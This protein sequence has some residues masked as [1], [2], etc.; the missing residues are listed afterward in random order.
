MQVGACYP[1][2]LDS[3]NHSWLEPRD[4]S[5]VLYK[6]LVLLHSVGAEKIWEDWSL[7]HHNNLLYLM[8]FINTLLSF[9]FT[10]IVRL[11]YTCWYTVLIL[12]SIILMVKSYDDYISN[13]SLMSDCSQLIKRGKGFLKAYTL[14]HTPSQCQQDIGKR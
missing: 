14:I 13:S 6:E 1:W 2:G 4:T 10:S 5:W 12:W 9:P 8:V 3:S 11:G 7:P